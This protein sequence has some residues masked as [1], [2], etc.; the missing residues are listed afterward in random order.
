[1]SDKGKVKVEGKYNTI[2]TVD[3]A[4]TYFIAHYDTHVVRGTGLVDTGWRDLEDGITLLEYRLSTGKIITLPKFKEY[5]HLVDVSQTLETGF[6]LYHYVA[7][8]G[9][10]G[11]K[12]ISYKIILKEG[13]N[14]EYKIGD[15]VVDLEKSRFNSPY[16]KLGKS[17]D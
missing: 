7:I 9:N 1:M 15:V 12:L 4:D 10:T 11:D 5:L 13:P 16:W 17:E 2:Y 6:C 14:L 3:P 8:I